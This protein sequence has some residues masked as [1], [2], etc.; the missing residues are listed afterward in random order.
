MNFCSKHWV[1]IIGH[2][3]N[4]VY[5]NEKCDVNLLITSKS[6]YLENLC[7]VI[8]KCRLFINLHMGVRVPLFSWFP[9]FWKFSCAKI[10]CF[11]FIF[12]LL[13][14]FFFFFSI[15]AQFQA[16]FFVFCL[17]PLTPLFK[18]QNS[19]ILWSAILVSKAGKNVY[20]PG[21][22]HIFPQLVTCCMCKRIKL[23]GKK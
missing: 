21:S 20:F 15:F 6:I 14:F 22:W 3:W 4:R 23:R 5:K 8:L 13:G 12:R 7:E 11:S 18:L 19:I 9:R 17:W 2:L 1:I 10:S 16:V